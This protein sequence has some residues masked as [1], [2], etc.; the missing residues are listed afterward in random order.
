M[1]KIEDNKNGLFLSDLI[2]LAKRNGVEPENVCLSLCVSEIDAH[3]SR[4]SKVVTDVEV[5]AEYGLTGIMW[6][7]LDEKAEQIVN[8]ADW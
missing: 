6:L 3:T 2:E 8:K 1:E 7:H 4:I 5:D